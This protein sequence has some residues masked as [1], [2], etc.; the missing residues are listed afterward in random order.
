MIA[1]L[2]GLLY[3]PNGIV[4]IAPWVSSG[5]AKTLPPVSPLIWAWG[6]AV[7]PDLQR[8]TFGF[9]A[10]VDDAIALVCLSLAWRPLG[11]PLLLQ[12]FVPALVFF[13]GA[14]IP[15]IG[16]GMLVAY[17]PF[18]LLLAAF[19]EPKQLLKPFWN[20]PI[21]WPLFALAVIIGALFLPQGWQAFGAQLAGKDAMALDYGWATIIEHLG[22]LWLLALFAS[23]RRPGSTLLAL[24]VALCLFYLGA[25]AIAVPENPGSW[26]LAGGLLALLGGVCYVT[27]VVRDGLEG[28]RT[29]PTNR[30]T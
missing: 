9:S 4:T 11:R 20:G 23:F 17:S 8:W 14:N 7:S 18:F 19:P 30:E 26:G 27:I 6:Q 2:L 25:A 1:V 13:L 22:I 29:C 15:F 5:I 12:V 28:K 16:W 24:L 10:V 21:S 3:L